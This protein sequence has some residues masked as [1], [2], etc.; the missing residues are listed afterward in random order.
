MTTPGWDAWA[1]RA[2]AQTRADVVAPAAAPS[3]L[4]EA[5][6]QAGAK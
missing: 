4:G 1:G 2:V 3:A 5:Q 6:H